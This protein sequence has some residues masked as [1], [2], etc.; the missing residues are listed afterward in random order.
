MMT[1]TKLII[2]AALVALP[3]SV[4]SV[5]PHH[6]NLNPNGL[7]SIPEDEEWEPTG[8]HQTPPS[9]APQKGSP[10]HDEGFSSTNT[11]PQSYKGESAG[12]TSYPLDQPL[13][14]IL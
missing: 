12:K 4:F 9:P 6:S 7:S 8:D 5:L 2:S 1:L 13:G 3:C 14:P 11:S 10:P